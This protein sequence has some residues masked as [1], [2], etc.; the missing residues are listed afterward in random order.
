[1]FDS[2]TEYLDYLIDNLIAEEENR[3]KFRA[4][5]RQAMEQL[6]WMHEDRINQQMLGLVMKNDHWASSAF[7]KWLTSQRA[8]FDQQT[9]ANGPR[10]PN[11]KAPFLDRDGKPVWTGG[12]E[13]WRE[14]HHS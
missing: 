12:M 8:Y 9:R 2:W 7:G 4:L 11:K 13:E 5:K 3:Q 10:D 6:P 14:R 1:M